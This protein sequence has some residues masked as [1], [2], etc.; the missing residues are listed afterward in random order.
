MR[1]TTVY[2][3]RKRINGHNTIFKAAFE[4][5]SDKNVEYNDIFN[6]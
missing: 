3:N 1:L 5:P 4:K 2:R 6:T